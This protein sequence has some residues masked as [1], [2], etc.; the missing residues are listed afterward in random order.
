MYY[1]AVYSVLK[2]KG[3]ETINEVHD[4][5]GQFLVIPSDCLYI[6]EN[7]FYKIVAIDIYR[8]EVRLL[9]TDEKGTLLYDDYDKTIKHKLRIEKFEKIAEKLEY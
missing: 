3:F 7:H 5:I 6:I 2:E 4:Y 1:E 8:M 9:E